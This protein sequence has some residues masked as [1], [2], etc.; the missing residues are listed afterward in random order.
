[1]LRAALAS[2][3]ICLLPGPACAAGDYGY[4]PQPP[5][6]P[7]LDLRPFLG[8]TDGQSRQAGPAKAQPALPSPAAA[9]GAQPQFVIQVGAFGD[10]NAALKLRTRLEEFGRVWLESVELNGKKLHRVRFGGF[11]SREAAQ[12]Q[13][14]HLLSMRLVSAAVIVSM[15]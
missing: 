4:G 10:R 9:A 7:L 14:D 8:V 5:S 11:Q 13:A 2:A 1:M 12:M 15:N 3:T 6:G